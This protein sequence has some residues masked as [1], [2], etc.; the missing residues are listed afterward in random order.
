MPRS[1]AP[2]CFVWKGNG[3]A[4][5]LAF[6]AVGGR[7]P[8]WLQRSAHSYTHL[9]QPQGSWLGL[10]SCIGF[11]WQGFGSGGGYRGG[12]CKKLLEASPVS[13]GANA[14]WLQDGP[15]ARQGQAHQRQR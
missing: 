13:N 15:T 1:A 11:G 9:Q 12:F 3:F 5:E 10:L 8:Q 6:A 2:I 7:C 4:L 14:S